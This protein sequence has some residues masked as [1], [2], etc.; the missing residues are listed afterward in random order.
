MSSILDQ[1]RVVL[2]EPQ[3][4]INIAAT[5]RAMKN[6]GVGVLR[7]IRPVFYEDNY[8]EMIAHNT[9][10]I[11]ARIEH[12]DTVDSALADCVRVAGFTGRRRAAKWARLDPREAA[13]DLLAHAADGPVAVMFGRE[14]DGLPAEVLD[15]AHVTVHIPTTEHAS[16]NVAQAVLVALYE[17][18][19]ASGDA[20]RTLQRPRKHAPP[21]TSAEFEQFY[22]S[23]EQALTAMDFFRSRNPEHVMRSVRSL[24]YRANPDARELTLVRAMAIEVLRTIDR[25]ERR[26]GAAAP[27]PGP[28]A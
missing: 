15:R 14:D 9:R 10:D 13:T 26:V 3:K 22:A 6:M 4:P 24:A 18:H 12:H 27:Q 20:T 21:P 17:L 11:Q 19:V 28:D 2:Y 8:I 25:I 16:L 7:L 5:V 23:A 1:V